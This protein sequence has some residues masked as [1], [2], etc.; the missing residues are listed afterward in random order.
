[1]LIHGGQ[2]PSQ[3]VMRFAPLVSKPGPVLDIACGSGRHLRHFLSLGYQ[4]VGVDIDTRGVADLAGEPGVEIVAA[5]LEGGPWPFGAR[6]FA[7]VVVTNY[8]H[9]PLMPVL[10]DALAPGGILIYETYARGNER[11]G[12]PSSPS[13]LLRANE[14]LELAAGRLH[15]IAFEQG[16]VASPKAAVVQRIAAVAD[17]APGRGLDGDPEPRPL[18]AV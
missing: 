17:L 6:L 4:G 7:G 5:D 8:L 10:L 16:E 15:V 3:W 12:R 13:Y 18:P 14:L 11:F 2:T 1:M 9:R